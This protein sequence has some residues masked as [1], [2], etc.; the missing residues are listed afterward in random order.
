MEQSTKS[1]NL[2][3]A[4]VACGCHVCAFFH[5]RDDEYEILLPFLKEG[6][7]SGD[8]AIHIIDKEHRAE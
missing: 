1:V 7:G 6:L 2:A 5:S 3:R 4:R 8:K